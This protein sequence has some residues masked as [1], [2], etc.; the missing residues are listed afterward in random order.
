MIALLIPLL[1]FLVPQAAL[2]LNKPSASADRPIVI[3]AG[4]DGFRADYLSRGQSPLLS[5]MAAGP[6][7]PKQ[8]HVRPGHSRSTLSSGRSQRSDQPGLVVRIPP[9]LGHCRTARSAAKPIYISRKADGLVGQNCV[10]IT[11]RTLKP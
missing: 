5:R 7:Y 3:L 10:S 4:L 1:V 8:H 11:G 2:A 6:R 9:H